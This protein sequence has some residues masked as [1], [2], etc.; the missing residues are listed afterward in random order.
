[1]NVK[2][3]LLDLLLAVPL[4][5]GLVLTVLSVSNAVSASGDA[6]KGVVAMLLGLVGVPI[7]YASAAVILRR[8]RV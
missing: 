6:D 4:A 3:Y 8:A 1:V 5:I 2:R 7:L